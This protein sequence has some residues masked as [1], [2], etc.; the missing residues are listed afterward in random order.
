MKGKKLPERLQKAVQRLLKHRYALLVLLI[1]VALLMLPTGRSTEKKTEVAAE[2]EAAP[3]SGDSVEARLGEL[4][5]QVEGAGKVRVMLTVSAGE[6]TVYQ[7]DQTT[8]QR[9]SGDETEKT[10][11]VTTVLVSSS[12]SE[13]A[14]V[15]VKV[16][17][18]VYQG[19]VVVAEGGGTPSVRLDLVRAVSSLTGLGADRITVVKMK[20]N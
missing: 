14:P 7:T 16:L 2:P 15:P 1:G 18:P 4:L 3:S 19:A 5:S 11:S 20:V 9:Q 17:S 6:E 8:E 10:V 13:E 12:S